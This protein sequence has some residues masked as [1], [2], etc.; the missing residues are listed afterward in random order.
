MFQDAARFGR[1]NDP[2]RCGA[3]RGLRPQVC[4]RI[5]REYTYVF[6]AVSPHDG[7]LD[8]L[9]LSDVNV[10]FIAAFGGGIGGGGGGSPTG[11]GSSR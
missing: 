2:R 9:V 6:A 5:V 1:I 10:T 3:P 7:A 11:R 8:T 4:A